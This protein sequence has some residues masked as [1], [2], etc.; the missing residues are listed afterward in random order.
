MVF[1]HLLLELLADS[2]LISSQ[3]FFNLKYIQKLEIYEF[4]ATQGT[5]G[6]FSRCSD[7]EKSGEAAR[8]KPLAQSAL[9]YYCAKCQSN[10]R[11]HTV[12]TCTST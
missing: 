10:R 6:F 1:V 7:T 11:F 2:V 12:I 5:R 8:K 3:T 4:D 9:I